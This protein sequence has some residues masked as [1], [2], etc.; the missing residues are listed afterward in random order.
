VLSFHPLVADAAHAARLG[1][2]IAGSL[3][4]ARAAAASLA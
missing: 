4:A 3:Q 2:S 1:R